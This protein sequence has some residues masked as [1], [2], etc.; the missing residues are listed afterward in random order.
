MTNYQPDE[1]AAQESPRR[2]IM[3]LLGLCAA[4]WWWSYGLWDLWGPDEGRYVQIARELLGRA[5]WFM[6]T[7]HGEPYNQ[8]PPLPF[9]MF[10]WMLKLGGG[11]VNVWLVRLPPMLFATGSVLLTYLIG[12]RWWGARTGLLAALILLAA[13]QFMDNAQPAELDMLLCGGAT[14]ALAG[15]LLR[16]PSPEA[17]RAVPLGWPLATML[18][19]GVIIGFFIKGPVVLLFVC[20]ALLGACLGRRSPQ[21][22]WAARVQFGLPVLLLLAFGWMR[23][24]EAAYGAAF[25]E[26]QMKT[27]TVDRL[28]HA[29]HSEAF[30]YYIPRLFTSIYAPWMLI[31]LFAYMRAWREWRAKRPLPE[32]I[33][34]LLG[35]TLISFLVFSIFSGKRQSYLLPLMPGLALLTAWQLDAWYARGL[36]ARWL[37]HALAALAGVLCVAAALL[38]LAPLLHARLAAVGYE[39]AMWHSVV[40]IGIAIGFALVLR[41]ARRAQGELPPLM[42]ALIA[43]LMLIGLTQFAILNPALDKKKST[44]AF[45]AEMQQYLATQGE[46]QL[47]AFEKAAR[48]MYHIYGNY[49]VRDLQ[50]D[51]DLLDGPAKLPRLLLVRAEDPGEQKTPNAPPELTKF[52]K[53]LLAHGFTLQKEFLTTGD[54]LRVYSHTPET[55]K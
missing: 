49:A 16:G 3:L 50:E 18:W 42:H 2:H 31:A 22:L 34:D 51:G 45:A 40:A 25:V 6:L 30:Y 5:N 12:R 46:K 33:P 26:A 54:R 13:P 47:G 36:R 10:A 53:K 27:A 15:W 29:D 52:E 14:L 19:L 32:P 20:S 44:R 24:Q 55:A 41:H 4:L 43:A 17:R 39:A 48:P 23:V 37:S 38:A 1:H 9:W 8:K 11:N 28:V 35:L 21:P 7:V